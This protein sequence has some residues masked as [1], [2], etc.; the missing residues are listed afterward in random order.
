LVLDVADMLNDRIRAVRL[1]AASL[2][3]TNARDLAASGFRPALDKAVKEYRAGQMANLD[4][5]ESNRNLG[6]LSFELGDFVAAVESFR[7]AIRQQPSRSQL[8]TEL[9]QILASMA[10]DPN[11][12]D[13]WKKVG[14]TEEEI[15]L[16]REEEVNLLLR[17]ATLLPGDAGPHYH[18]GRLLVLLKRD[19]EALEAFR[20]ACRLA[21]NDY[22]Y[23]MWLAL[24][25]ERL[26]RWEEG[27]QALQRMAKLRPDAEEWKGLRYRFLDTIRKQNAGEAEQ[28]DDE[29]SPPIV[30][31]KAS[32][33]NDAAP[34]L[35]DPPGTPGRK[36]TPPEQLEETAR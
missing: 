28:P 24:I 3:A 11:Q 10:A 32:E 8:R 35:T 19:E 36:A 5:A 2:L 30:E 21:P 22:D 33:A 25:C 34:A 20:E 16:L 7:T 4:R 26:E 17:D 6:N 23:W 9:A 31:E 15:R 29:S 13:A 1:A 14:G 27:V 12:A 18:R